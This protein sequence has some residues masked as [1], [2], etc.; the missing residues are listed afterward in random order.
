MLGKGDPKWDVRG[1]TNREC[2]LQTRLALYPLQ[3][4]DPVPLKRP[5]EQGGASSQRLFMSTTP[6][7]AS[8]GKIYLMPET[9]S[10]HL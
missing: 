10:T 3:P 7:E 4:S 5:R 8:R 9:R 2:E 1:L 6:L